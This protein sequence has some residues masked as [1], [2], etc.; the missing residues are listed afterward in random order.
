MCGVFFIIL[1]WYYHKVIHE[2]PVDKKYWKILAIHE[3]FCG[4]LKI[5]QFYYGLLS[6]FKQTNEN[7]SQEN[8]K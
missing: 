4:F 5:L 2:H 6:E 8:H 3:K 1:I 7:S